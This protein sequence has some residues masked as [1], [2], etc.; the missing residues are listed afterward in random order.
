[1]LNL[2]AMGIG[3]GL[4]APPIPPSARGQTA[5]RRAAKIA[6]QDKIALQEMSTNDNER[7]SS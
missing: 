5:N 6:L 1:M 4:I 2:G 3:G 7:H